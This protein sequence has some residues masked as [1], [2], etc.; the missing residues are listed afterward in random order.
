V[1]DTRLSLASFSRDIQFAVAAVT[2]SADF[3][4]TAEAGIAT[5]VLAKVD[6]SPVSVAD[7]AVRPATSR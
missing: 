3:V 1:A 7:F 5:D 4:R 6:A 2:A